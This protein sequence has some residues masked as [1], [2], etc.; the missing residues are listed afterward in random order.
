M[1]TKTVSQGADAGAQDQASQAAE[2]NASSNGSES[3]SQTPGTAAREPDAVEALR[4]QI[5]EMRAQMAHIQS[6]KDAEIAAANRRANELVERLAANRSAA[7]KAELKRLARE[8]PDSF[9]ERWLS[10]MEAREALEE[11]E[12]QIAEGILRTAYANPLYQVIPEADK[13]R[14]EAEVLARGGAAI[15]V[16]HA[17]AAEAKRLA[18]TPNAELTRQI[19]EMRAKLTALEN[20]A[21]AD[22]IEG[23]EGPEKPPPP[24]ALRAG[25][26]DLS[27]VKGILA[28]R[29]AGVIDEADAIQKIAALRN[30]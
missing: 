7:E 18:E 21:V 1:T 20:S 2:G 30:G 19:E 9:A 27:T 22:Q 8:D 15:D 26:Y 28:A 6:V 25:N 14:I 12:A 16:V 23:G 3:G 29:R 24:E 4:K 10:S 11:R 13:R 5:D 17:F